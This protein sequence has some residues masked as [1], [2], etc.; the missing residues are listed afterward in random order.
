MTQSQTVTVDQQ[1]IL[2]RANEVEA[3]MADPPTDVPIT[4]CELTAAKKRRPTAGIVRRQHAG[5]PGG[6]C[7]RAAASGD[8]AAQRGQGVW[9]G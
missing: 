7:Q 2:N 4:P 5:I 8:L 1:E 6:R 9:R 3:P